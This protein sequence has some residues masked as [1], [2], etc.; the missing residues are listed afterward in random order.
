V[1]QVSGWGSAIRELAIWASGLFFL[2]GAA[3]F[4][5]AEPLSGNQEDPVNKCREDV[6]PDGTKAA[7]CLVFHPQ[8]KVASAPINTVHEI[9]VKLE[10]T[11]FNPDGT[12]LPGF[13]RPA[14]CEGETTDGQ[15][16]R[17]EIRLWVAGGP[18]KDTEQRGVCDDSGRFTMSYPGD[19]GPGTD[20]ILACI[21]APNNK[22]WPCLNDPM[23]TA[24]MTW[25]D[26]TPPP[27]TAKPT[28][29][30]PTAGGKCYPLP[31]GSREETWCISLDPET[32]SRAMGTEQSLDVTLT[33]DGSPQAGEFIVL[34][35]VGGPNSRTLVSGRGGGIVEVTDRAGG[36]T[37]GADGRAAFFYVGSGGTGTDTI[38][39]CRAAVVAPFGCTAVVDE[40]TVE[41]TEAPPGVLGEQQAPQPGVT[42]GTGGSPNQLQGGPDSGV[43]SLAPLPNS[44]PLWSPI[45]GAVAAIGLLVA[46]TLLWRNR[47]RGRGEHDSAGSGSH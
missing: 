33:L 13:P 34:E 7:L 14:P 19:G 40:A 2:A 45:A 17:G 6:R 42:G 30:P 31:A 32:S 15:P 23:A 10:L 37:T 47:L 46:F 35:I 12:V 16:F 4:L 21:Y 28:V 38:R 24:E 36:D 41:W 1:R 8:D 29:T 43:G 20:L 27:Q 9:T 5:A 11:F 3:T 26:A 39:A 25:V 18:N 22:P 44:I